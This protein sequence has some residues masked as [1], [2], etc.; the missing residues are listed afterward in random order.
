MDILNFFGLQEDPF[1]LTP[2]PLF[3]FPSV[4]H[5]EALSSLDYIMQ[6]REGFCLVTGEPGTGKTTL[7][8]VCK[9]KW[10][11][12]AEIALILTPRLSPDEFLL[13]VLEDLQVHLQDKNKN[14]IMKAFRDFLITKHEQGKLV[15]IIVD[16][17]QNVP[18]ETLEELRLLSNLETNKEKLLQIILLAQ[19]ELEER[20]KGDKLRQLN[21]RITERISL[22]PLSKTETIE[23]INYRLMKAGKGFMKIEGM[24][25]DPIYKFSAGIPRII[26]LIASRTIMVAYL[27]GNN[28]IERKHATYAISHLAEK[29]KKN[30]SRS[31]LIY[32]IPCCILLCSAFG[33]VYY[34]NN[35]QKDVYQEHPVEVTDTIKQHDQKIDIIIDSEVQ[36]AVSL[37]T[38]D[39]AVPEEPLQEDI[40][41][42][43]PEETTEVLPAVK[44]QA[45]VNVTAAVVRT[46]PDFEATRIGLLYAGVLIDI[47]DETKDAEDN[48]WYKIFTAGFTETWI[49]ER[50]VT[51]ITKPISLR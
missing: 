7:I 44:R 27:E 12:Q 32:V 10:Q 48:V 43:A 19:P 49:S 22:T 24:V 5:K 40:A 31:V 18:D 26:N 36:P 51:I 37:E 17:A 16:E 45:V 30:L 47:E 38:E 15:I 8:N 50:V 2:D 9:E 42:K 29:R 25:A 13:S 23:Y 35:P 11:E 1:R 41:S 3:F 4:I 39:P 28:T 21:Q 33:F 34:R 46:G 6:Q 14:E 20:L